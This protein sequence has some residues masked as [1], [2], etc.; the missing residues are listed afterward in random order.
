MFPKRQI[1]K[2]K[3]PTHKN[4]QN[5]NKKGITN[6]NKPQ[7]SIN[8]QVESVPVIQSNSNSHIW[9]PKHQKQPTAF[10]LQANLQKALIYKVTCTSNADNQP[11]V[12]SSPSQLFSFITVVGNISGNPSKPSSARDLSSGMACSLSSR[13]WGSDSQGTLLSS[14]CW[15]PRSEGKGIEGEK[16]Q[17]NFPDKRCFQN[18]FWSCTRQKSSHTQQTCSQE[19]LDAYW[20][21]SRLRGFLHFRNIPLIIRLD[22]NALAGTLPLTSTL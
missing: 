14:H 2:N 16:F 13:V 4:P 3:K 10:P 22:M 5:K 21:R 6:P 19:I 11:A 7:K 8:V 12:T 15:S 17:S 18:Y 20:A 1:T 9:W